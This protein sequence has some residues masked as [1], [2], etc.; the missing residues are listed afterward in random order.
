M[1][2]HAIHLNIPQYSSV[3]DCVGTTLSKSRGRSQRAAMLAMLA[4]LAK[5]DVL[6]PK[7]DG[8]D[9][10]TK[11]WGSFVISCPGNVFYKFRT[12]VLYWVSTMKVS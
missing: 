6:D 4:M 9:S 7:S 1:K 5:S 12:E 10:S 8:L 11:N 2:A 3:K